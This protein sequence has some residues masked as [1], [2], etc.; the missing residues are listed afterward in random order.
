MSIDLKDIENGGMSNMNCLEC[1]GVLSTVSEY[2]MQICEC[3]A[4]K[5]GLFEH[6]CII[7]GVALSAEENELGDGRCYECIDEEGI[8]NG[9]I[10]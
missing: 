1:G 10:K 5:L 7:C 9:C 6:E 8:Y 2:N 4:E 3:C